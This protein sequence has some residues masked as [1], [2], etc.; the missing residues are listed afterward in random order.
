M[1]L[2]FEVS[3]AGQSGDGKTPGTAYYGTISSPQSWTYAYNNGI[4]YVGQIGN[5]DLTIGTGGSLSIEPGITI[6]LCTNTTD[7]IVTGTGSITAD[8]TPLSKITF[9]RNYPTFNY[10]GHISFQTMG[11]AAA[12]LFDNCVIEYGDVS[13]FSVSDPHG[14]GGGIFIDFNNV[15]ITNCTLQHNKSQ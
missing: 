7:L 4:I 11:S 6:Y 9:T 8:G 14:G 1:L 5:E 10:W 12:S 3:L 15:S 2:L 13:S